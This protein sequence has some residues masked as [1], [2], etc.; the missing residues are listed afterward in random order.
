[1][2]VSRSKKNTETK[3]QSIA[4][5]QKEVSEVR[6]RESRSKKISQIKILNTTIDQKEVLEAP[7]IKSRQESLTIHQELIKTKK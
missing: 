6:K 5:N 1:M 2:N 7:T 4:T 3:I